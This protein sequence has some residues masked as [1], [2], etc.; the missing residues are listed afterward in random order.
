[1]M[2]KTRTEPLVVLE[3]A[4]KVRL[5][6]HEWEYYLETGIKNYYMAKQEK[7]VKE[8]NMTWFGW[9]YCKKRKKPFFCYQ[10]EVKDE[11]KMEN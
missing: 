10:R 7:M 9:G 5:K 6:D 11:F 3:W 8:M 2:K 4:S 1:M